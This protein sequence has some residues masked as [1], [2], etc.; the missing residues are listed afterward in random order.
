MMKVSKLNWI[1]LLILQCLIQNKNKLSILEL[2]ALLHN[3]NS[4]NITYNYLWKRVNYMKTLGIL[5]GDKYNVRIRKDLFNEITHLIIACLS[6][7]EKLC[8]KK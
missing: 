4:K 6:I 2:K 7:E 1:D 3:N 8:F 5:E